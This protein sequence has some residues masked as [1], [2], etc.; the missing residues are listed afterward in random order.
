MV[1]HPL[2]FC[3]FCGKGSRRVGGSAR[4]DGGDNGAET[5]RDTFRPMAATFKFELV[6]PER[7]SFAAKP[8]QVVVPGLEGEFAVLAGHAPVISTLRPAFSTHA[9]RTAGGA[10]SCAAG[11]PKSRRSG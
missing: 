9:S 7:S 11:W 1:D 4:Q 6:T 2:F 5:D 3:P 8:R 10:C